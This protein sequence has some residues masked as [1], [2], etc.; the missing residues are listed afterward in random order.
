M[1]DD[2]YLMTGSVFPRI[3]PVIKAYFS[4]PSNRAAWA[5]DSE[6]GKKALKKERNLAKPACLGFGY[7]MGPKKFYKTAYEAGLDISMEESIQMYKAYW[8]VF[9]G[10]KQ[11]AKQLTEVIETQ[12]SIINPFGYRLTPEPHKAFNAVIQSS[13]SGV[14]DIFGLYFFE[15]LADKCV[16]YMY[17]ACIHDEHIYQIPEESIAMCEQLTKEALDE[18][19]ELLGWSVPMRI[20]FVYG[21]T[22]AEIK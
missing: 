14:M 3:G 2:I 22:F 18:T 8:S 13:A 12:K 20:G 16:K 21:K 9:A 11:L 17:V 15:L 6:V 5:K 19:N 7:N 1:I 4:D 10:V